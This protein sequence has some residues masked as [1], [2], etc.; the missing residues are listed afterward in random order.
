MTQ[1]V[2]PENIHT[3]TME[4]IGFSR[5]EVGSII[6]CLIC[7]RGGGCTIGK[8]FQMVLVTDKGVIKKKH[9]SLP[10]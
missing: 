8:F 5:E 2:V 1:C 7:Q 10:Q 3:T 9:K 4:G 6:I